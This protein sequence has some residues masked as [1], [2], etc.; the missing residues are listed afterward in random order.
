MKT[1]EECRK[2]FRYA[3]GKV[4]QSERLKIV[5]KVLQKGGGGRFPDFSSGKEQEMARYVTRGYF[6][7]L[8]P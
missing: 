1:V 7:K 2:V 6:L 8:N 3:S 4:G 5:P